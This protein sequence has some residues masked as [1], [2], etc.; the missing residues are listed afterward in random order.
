MKKAVEQSTAFFLVI[1]YL[2]AMKYED[3]IE[4]HF[5]N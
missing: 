4:N 2:L 5:I 1:I 3:F